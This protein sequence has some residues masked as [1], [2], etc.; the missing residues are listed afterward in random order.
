MNIEERS[1]IT[2]DVF[3]NRRFG[4]NPLGL[5]PDATG[6]DDAT[7][8][9]IA[10]E[11]NLSETVFIHRQT[12]SDIPLLRIFTPASELPFAGHPTVGAAI[13][14]AEE[15]GFGDGSTLTMRT[16]A[17]DVAA[18]ISRSD[19]KL[20]FAEIT[21]PQKAVCRPAVSA[22]ACAAALS[23]TPADIPFPPR[24]CDAGNPFTVIPVGSREA[25]S[26]ATLNHD[27]WRKGPGAGEAPKLFIV[28]MDDWQNGRD[29]HARMFAP[30][31]GIAEDPA[32]GS[33][34]VALAALLNELQ[35]PTEGEHIWQVWQGDD[36]GRPSLM[37]VRAV[38]ENGNVESAHVGGTAVRVIAGSI[39]V[40]QEP[41]A[42]A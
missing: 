39:R 27:A 25:L 18:A 5:L 42:S 8:Q 37:K 6:L 3:T 17:G 38:V 10:A 19:A 12:D 33:A 26:R 23:L 1:F 11:V 31:I 24:V 16:P 35:S 15:H 2:L 22:E 40:D 30:S 32:T 28:Y 7:M 34:A 41:A 20:T 13:Y 4:G 9:R 14:L 21:A 36:M 29:V